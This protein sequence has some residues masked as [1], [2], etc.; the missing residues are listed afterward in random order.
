MAKLLIGLFMAISFQG[1]SQL[2]IQAISDSVFVYT[3]YKEYNQM[4]VP[5]NGVYYLTSEGIVMIDVPWDT[6]QLPILLDTMMKMHNMQPIMSISTHFH[7]DRTAGLT[8]LDSIGVKTYSTSFTKRLCIEHGEEQATNT[9]IEDTTFTVGGHS[10][11][12]YYPGKGHAPDNILV[13]L[14]DENILIGGCFVK[15]YEAKDLGYLG[16]ANVG[17][18]LIS[19]KKVLKKYPSVDLII[20]GHGNWKGTKSI[21]KTRKLLGKFIRE[22]RR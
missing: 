20:P 13:F 12:T 1:S 21:K 2:T 9:F 17:S 18:W 15:S 3:T 5:S 7:D 16:D 22:N 19:T 10:F 8:Y 14:K 11:S 6:S 4:M